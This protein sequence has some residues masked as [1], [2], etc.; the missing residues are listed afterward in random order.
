MASPYYSPSDVHIDSALNNLPVVSMRATALE[1]CYSVYGE[2]ATSMEA[3]DR[4]Y[5]PNAGEHYH[6][7]SRHGDFHLI[8]P[9][10]YENPFL[11]ATSRSVISDIHRMARQLSSIDVPRPLAVICTLFGLEPPSKYSSI[12]ADGPL[13]QA[14][15]VWNEIGDICE[16]ESFADGHRKTIV[17]HTLNVLLLPGIHHDGLSRHKFNSSS[18]SLVN[19][20]TGSPLSSI[21]HFALPSLPIPGT[22]LS[23]P[24]PLH[25]KLRIL[26]RLSFNEQ[27]CVT[28][29]RD[30]WDVK[31]VI[32]LV[33]GVSLAQWIITRLTA[34]GLSYAARL[35]PKRKGQSYT[36]RHSDS[37]PILDLGHATT[38]GSYSA[39]TSNALGLEDI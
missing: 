39:I 2:N 28:H 3:V 23:V 11:T 18:E 31:D 37:R 5:E 14:L 1:V 19:P 33:P 29:H 9:T 17:E 16:C 15:R 20:V 27:G 30:F 21:P 32:G 34:T 36:S 24:S 13:F 7:T 26:T 10:R 22:S 6:T 38:I 12:Q 8:L 4:F 35:L 25:F